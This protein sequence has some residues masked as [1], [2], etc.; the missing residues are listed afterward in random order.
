MKSI[1][2]IA[3][4]SGC[5][6]PNIGNAFFDYGAREIIKQAVPD[7]E[8]FLTGGTGRWYFWNGQNS[9]IM[10]RLKRKLGWVPHNQYNAFEMSEILDVDAVAFAGMCMSEEFVYIN[11]PTF[12]ELARRNIPILIIGGG[13]CAYTPQEAAVYSKFLKDLGNVYVITRDTQSADM[14]DSSIKNVTCGIDCAFFL[15]DAYKPLASAIGEY[16]VETFDGYPNPPGI[17]HGGRQV[18][19]AHHDTWGKMPKR[20]FAKP[21]TMLSDLPEDYLTLYAN[22]TETHSDRVHA[23][24]ATLI[25]GNKAKLYSKTPR[26]ALFKEMKIENITSE[27]VQLDK[28][29]TEQKKVEMVK[30]VKQALATFDIK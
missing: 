2:K 26:K 29:W 15:S 10:T 28:A 6:S 9:N 20:Y 27:V 8:V 7:A 17:E 25:Y 11:G 5:W 18:L 19:Y 14:L 24:I 4:Y 22:V 3:V 21:R 30:S 13:M 12:R 16:D 23:C 1:K